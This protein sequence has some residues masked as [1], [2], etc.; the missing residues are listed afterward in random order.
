[1]RSC[2][3]EIYNFQNYLF[4]TAKKFLFKPSDMSDKQKSELSKKIVRWVIEDMLGWT[5]QEA[6]EHFGEKEI[7]TF[8]LSGIAKKIIYPDDISRKDY[9]YLISIL[10]PDVIRY[11]ATEGI[12]KLWDM[13]LTGIE[14]KKFPP[15]LFVG[16]SGKERVYT[17]LNEFNKRYIPAKDIPD[18]YR[19]YSNSAMINKK[20]NEAKLY[21]S[22]SKYYTY[23]IEILHRML[24]ELLGEEDDYLYA[25]YLYENVEKSIKIKHEE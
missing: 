22:L 23:P 13:L 10:Y 14:I 3:T 4:G 16:E 17:L 11:D 25:L 15:N 2:D 6:K 20:L 12:I 24:R 19:I 7:K 18:L 9:P 1:M 8:K 21:Q 5:P